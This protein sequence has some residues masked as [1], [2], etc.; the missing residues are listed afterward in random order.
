MPRFPFPTAWR[1][2]LAFTTILCAA[3]PAIADP[4]ARTASKA[5]ASG[6]TLM[7]ALGGVAVLGAIGLAGGG[8]DDDARPAP[9]PFDPNRL[10]NAI[11]RNPQATAQQIQDVRARDEYAQNPALVSARLDNK[12]ALGFTGKGVHVGI[13]D[14]GVQTGNAAFSHLNI[15]SA[16]IAQDLGDRT[17]K[18]WGLSHATLVAQVLAGRAGDGDAARGVATDITLH[19]L[20][21]LSVGKEDQLLARDPDTVRAFRHAQN[22]GIDVIN[23]SMTVVNQTGTADLGQATRRTIHKDVLK[24]VG[25]ATRSGV[26]FVVGSGNDGLDNSNNTYAGIGLLPE[27]ANGQFLTVTALNRSGSAL[28]GFSNACGQT[29]AFCLSAVG[30]GIPVMVGRGQQIEVSGTSYAAPVVSGSIALLK[31]Q[32]PELSSRELVQL[33]LITADDLGA[34]GVDA[35]Y[36]HGR[37]NMN[38]AFAPVGDLRVVSG[39]EVSSSHLSLE[40]SR[41]RVPL[42]A[43]GVSAALGD[44]SVSALDDMNRAFALADDL[45]VNTDAGTPDPIVPGLLKFSGV[46]GQAVMI[47]GEH[48]AWMRHRSGAG[49]GYVNPEI[50]VSHSDTARLGYS[51]L[52]LIG[53]GPVLT[54]ETDS[55]FIGVAK[56]ENGAHS[57]WAGARFSGVRTSAGFVSEGDGLM[58]IRGP[59]GSGRTWFVSAAAEHDLTPRMTAR[60]EALYAR[61]KTH[62]GTGIIRNLNLEAASAQASLS[63]SDVAGGDLMVSVGTPLTAFQGDVSF[64]APAGRVASTGLETTGV[65]RNLGREGFTSDVPIDL[66]VS[67]TREIGTSLIVGASAVRRIM[68]GDED[69]TFA[70]ISLSAKF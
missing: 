56:G 3:H 13:L 62:D 34:Q 55:T 23:V 41:I 36:G 61:G 43:R 63:I 9:P 21:Y 7:W 57:L 46:D 44:V 59:I 25:D 32:F 70:G 50:L 27:Y 24:A 58:G 2:V 18:Y 4:S 29:Q 8:S 54:Y 6:N 12:I 30:D 49:I 22:A 14:E 38:Q 17:H 42:A 69:Q 31:E 1:S 37:L 68:P 11:R 5:T 48:G 47:A 16:F 19:D 28:A 40:G 39:D 60:I 15:G 20:S 45:L 51:P 10:K 65:I 66:G 26:I 67:Y 35:V 53:V 52:G 64:D 33:V